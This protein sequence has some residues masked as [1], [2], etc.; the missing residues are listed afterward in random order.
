MTSQQG[1]NNQPN[2]ARDSYHHDHQEIVD[3][4]LS[5]KGLFDLWS[6]TSS[7]YVIAPSMNSDACEKSRLTHTASN[8][9][10]CIGIWSK[11]TKENPFEMNENT[12]G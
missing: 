12:I 7:T 8:N 6:M 2:V 5:D 3:K 11:G 4:E 9:H 10:S 1:E